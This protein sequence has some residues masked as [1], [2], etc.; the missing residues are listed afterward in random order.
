MIDDAPS[1]YQVLPEVIVG[2]NEGQRIISKQSALD[3]SR[4]SGPL[5][6]GGRGRGPRAFSGLRLFKC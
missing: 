4:S 6:E 2:K 3:R 5:L 1:A